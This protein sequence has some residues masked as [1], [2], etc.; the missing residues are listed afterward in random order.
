M[1]GWKLTSG[2]TSN[3]NKS[4]INIRARAQ[5]DKEQLELID[6]IHNDK[7]IHFNEAYLS[8]L[9]KKK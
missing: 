1:N 4:F 2:P 8:L 9:A 3:V 7:D 6:Q 5:V